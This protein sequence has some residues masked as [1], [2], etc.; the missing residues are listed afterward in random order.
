MFFIY[1]SSDRLSN[2][3]FKY[4][5]D[6]KDMEVAYSQKINPKTASSES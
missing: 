2:W 3:V 1:L 5:R 6:S 4:D